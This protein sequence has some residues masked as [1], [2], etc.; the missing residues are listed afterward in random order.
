MRSD[1]LGYVSHEELLKVYN[2]ESSWLMNGNDHPQ[3]IKIYSS[4]TS[5][6]PSRVN[7]TGFGVRN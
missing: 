1:W 2:P 7:D 5:D 6:L 3:Y 4:I